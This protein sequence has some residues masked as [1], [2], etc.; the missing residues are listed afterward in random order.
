[1][2]EI[3][4]IADFF[5]KMKEDENFYKRVLVHAYKKSTMAEYPN[6]EKALIWLNNWLKIN[7]NEYDDCHAMARY[8]SKSQRE[9]PVYP[10][11]ILSPHTINVFTEKDRARFTRD[12]Y[13]YD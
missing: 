1:V 4:S 2:K 5:F 9:I 12:G 8:L 13:G 10:Q 6:Y 11:K 3:T 7:V